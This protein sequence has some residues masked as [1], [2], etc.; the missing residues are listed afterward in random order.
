MVITRADTPTTDP[1]PSH[2]SL[3]VHRA[4]TESIF[5]CGTWLILTRAPMESEPC[6]PIEVAD[7]G[8]YSPHSSSSDRSPGHPVKV[9]TSSHMGPRSSTDSSNNGSGARTPPRCAR[10]R[11]HGLKIPLRGHKR[12]CGFRH[13]T[14]SKCKLTAE[15]QRVMAA[16][17]AL[18]RAQAQDEIFGRQGVNPTGMDDGPSPPGPP[19]PPPPR[20]PVS[21]AS[22][23]S[24]SAGASANSVIVAHPNH[25][26]SRLI[27]GKYLGANH[28]PVNFPTATVSR[29]PLNHTSA[30]SSS[31]M[32][33][34]PFWAGNCVRMRCE[35][36]FR[37]NFFGFGK[38]WYWKWCIFC[39]TYV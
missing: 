14:C 2:A 21:G 10:C 8:S 26:I 4:C 13:C 5:L 25:S 20:S 23:S 19:S 29:V 15:R 30:S 33:G 1:S 12:Y 3:S 39:F 7:A 31:G 34:R 6:S 28:Q 9:I 24:P 11:N 36:R 17:T 22:S 37:A 16:Q 18:R 35:L 32:C 27:A 38:I